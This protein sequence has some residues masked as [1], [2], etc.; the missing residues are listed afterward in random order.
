MTVYCD[1][2]GDTAF[3]MARA[4]GDGVVGDYTRQ[5]GPGQSD[6]GRDC[7]WWIR[8]AKAGGVAVVGDDGIA[9]ERE[10]E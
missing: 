8:L 4:E 1:H 6:F 10:G 2:D 3:L 5:L 9:A 7:E